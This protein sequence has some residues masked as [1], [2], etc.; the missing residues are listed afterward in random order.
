[1]ELLTNKQTVAINEVIYDSAVEQ[2][3][4]CD[5]LLP[6]YCPDVVRILKCMVAPADV[7]AHVEGDKLT[8]D[9][10]ASIQVYYVGEESAIRCVDYKVPYSKIVELKSPP[11]N[12]IINCTATVSYLNCRAVNQRR[13]DIRGALS[14][15]CRVIGR[16]EEEVITSADSVELK[17]RLC[18][19]TDLVGQQSRTFSVREELELGYGKPPIGSIIRS[20]ACCNITDYK[21]VT[22]KVI[23]KGDLNLHVLYQGQDGGNQLQTM[24]YTLPVSQ[25]VDVDGVDEDCICDVRLQ[26][27]SVSLEPRPDGNGEC[28]TVAGDITLNAVVRV[29]RPQNVAM[30]EDCYSTKYECTYQARQVPTMRLE[31]CVDQNVMYKD[32]MD[33]PE[34][35]SA[36]LDTWS[37]VSGIQ[38]RM[39]DGR[40]MMDCK[41]TVSMF[42]MDE[43]Q[44]LTY[45]DRT[46]DYE[47]PIEEAAGM[48]DNFLFDPSVQVLS[49]SYS[50]SGSGQ[51]EVRCDL[52]I[53]GCIYTMCRK[54]AIC[55]IAVDEER[56][57]KCDPTVGLYL[58]RASKGETLWDIAKHYNTSTRYI[59]EENG[60]TDESLDDR[61]ML[62]IPMV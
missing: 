62:I 48:G 43:N 12:P 47:T 8:M 30:A 53:C 13:L 37:N 24:E 35:V 6:D 61:R 4:E 7:A 21:V 32:T 50:M 19:C 45:F 58:Y 22:G 2:P 38:T 14:I 11:A 40:M 41:I 56:P 10:I 1:M 25:I 28:I 36:V 55:E 46:V 60:L 3:V 57:K 23:I 59:M 39:A 18:D 44:Q 20:E 42:T 54:H 16:R 15:S 26:V 9:G 29:H 51:I 5:V 33:L 34:H 17:C 27:C 52:K 31:H 49:T